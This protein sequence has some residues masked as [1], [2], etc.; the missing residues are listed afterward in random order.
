MLVAGT[1]TFSK[2]S[3]VAVRRV[4]VAEHRQ[5]AQDRHARR[6]ARHEDHR[7]ALVAVGIVGIALAH[8]D[9]DL[10]ARIV[11][12]RGPPLAAR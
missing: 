10:A 3:R 1:R 9:E 7:L 11:G 8:E 5:V 4:V 12:S 2:R 6:V